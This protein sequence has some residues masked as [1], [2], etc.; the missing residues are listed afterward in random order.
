[1]SPTR[2]Y[3]CNNDVL[4]DQKIDACKLSTVILNNPI[5]KIFFSDLFTKASFKLECPYRVGLYTFTNVTLL[6]PSKLP[7]P[8]NVYFCSILKIFV[9]LFGSKKFVMQISLNMFFSL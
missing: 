5:A 9:K 8:K 6:I 4:F 7:L 1:M 3:M 2:N